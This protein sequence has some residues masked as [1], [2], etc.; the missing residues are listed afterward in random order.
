MPSIVSSVSIEAEIPEVLHDMM[1][2]YLEQHPGMDKDA[3][4]RAA[5]ALFL[6]QNG[7]TRRHEVSSIYLDSV[8]GSD[9]S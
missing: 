5:I 8:F 4:F 7:A 9:R 3:V 2:I 1:Q 6:L